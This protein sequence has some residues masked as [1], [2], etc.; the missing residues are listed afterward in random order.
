MM[1]ERSYEIEQRKK[2]Q[3]RK[4]A[5][6]DA[7]RKNAQYFKYE[8]NPALTE[9]E[10]LLIGEHDSVHLGEQ[11]NSVDEQKEQQPE[12][13]AAIRELQ[14]IDQNVRAHEQAHMAAGGA[15]AGSATFTYTEGP[16]GKRYV[17]GG[18]V[19][20]NAPSTSSP[21]DTIAVLEQVKRAALAPADPSPQDLR[22]A[23]S[24]TAKIQEAKTQKLEETAQEYTQQDPVEPAFLNEKL[25]VEVPERFNK[26]LNLDPKQ[27]TMFGKSYEDIY[28]SRLFDQ[29]KE[30]YAKHTEMVKNG[31]RL[32]VEPQY[33]LIA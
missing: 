17:T 33:S 21:E 28:R 19:P 32:A 22:V 12:E 10:R 27:Q 29:A 24:V 13:K 16:D 1:V 15:V 18:E 30:R 6:G 20:I 14:Q 26:E 5:A 25:D 4:E 9:L 7:Y 31:Y 3:Q 2:M 8:K 11:S 23:A